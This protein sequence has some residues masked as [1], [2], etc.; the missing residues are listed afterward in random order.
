M[1]QVRGM[2]MLLAAGVAF[3]RG[4]KIHTGREALFAFGLGVLALGL[5]VWHLTRATRR[6]RLPRC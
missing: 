1:E 3:Y 6:G 2:L 4:W 5:A